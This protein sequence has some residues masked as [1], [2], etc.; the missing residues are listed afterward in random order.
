MII[1]VVE[2]TTCFFFVMFTFVYD[3]MFVSPLRFLHG[4]ILQKKKGRYR[5]DSLVVAAHAAMV[6][7]PQLGWS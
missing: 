5:R 1:L 3:F 7:N 4:L 2:F 6:D